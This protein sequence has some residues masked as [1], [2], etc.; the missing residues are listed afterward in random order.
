MPGDALR[1]LSEL[2]DEDL[3]ALEPGLLAEL[4]DANAATK[5]VRESKRGIFMGRL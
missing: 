2:T 3:G 1:L 5:S 4:N